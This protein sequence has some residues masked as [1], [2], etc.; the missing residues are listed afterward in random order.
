[1]DGLAV[2]C[3]GTRRATLYGWRGQVLFFTHDRRLTQTWVLVWMTWFDLEK[4]RGLVKMQ[5]QL[6]PVKLSWSVATRIRTRNANLL[7]VFCCFHTQ[8]QSR[9]KDTLISQ[10]RQLRWVA[11]LLVFGSRRREQDTSIPRWW[12][13]VV[14]KDQICKTVLLSSKPLLEACVERRGG[15][16]P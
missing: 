6:Q 9:K 16:T 12:V 4:E 3:E 11:K 5:Q 2:Y 10:Q 7:E 15:Q 13:V 1:M 14:G 8:E